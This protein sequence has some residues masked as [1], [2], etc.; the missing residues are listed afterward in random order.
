MAASQNGERRCKVRVILDVS[1]SKPGKVILLDGGFH[2]YIT[3]W[4]KEIQSN[5]DIPYSS[6]ISYT[7]ATVL[8]GGLHIGCITKQ[9]II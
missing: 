5:L 6:T 7:A 1:Y 2:G 4:Q 8:D 9:C 3:K